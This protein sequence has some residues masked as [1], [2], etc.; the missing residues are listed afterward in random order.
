MSAT[1]RLLVLAGLALAPPAPAADPP[2]RY[3]FQPGQ[4]LAYRSATSFKYGE[5]AT[6]A[7]MN[8]DYDRTVW[9]VRANADGSFRLVL[10]ER[11]TYTT[12]RG[13][14]TYDRPART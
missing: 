11:D 8:H 5:G 4:E 14:K 12:V 1:A 3:K 6:A 7:T 10:R 13:D 9:V 2:P